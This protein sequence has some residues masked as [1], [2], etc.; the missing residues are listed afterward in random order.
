M[1]SSKAQG[2]LYP[3][4]SN[5]GTGGATGGSYARLMSKCQVVD[6]STMQS[7]P[8]SNPIKEVSKAIQ[9]EKSS[10]SILTA[11]E[12]SEIDDLMCSLDEEWN[13]LS[14]KKKYKTPVRII[15]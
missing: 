9:S 12:S 15:S 13:E 10:Q 7:I 1:N 5:E 2:V 3:E 11:T 4:G 8:P 14:S 6:T